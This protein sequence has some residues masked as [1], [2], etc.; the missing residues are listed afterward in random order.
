[1]K[2]SELLRVIVAQVCLHATM[3]G[4]R[5]ATPLLALQQGY[6]A[7]AVGLLIALFALTQV[8]LALPAGRF[9][10]RHGL[11]RPLW[12]SVIAASG[13]AGLAL[14]FPVFPVMCI[15]ALL[16]GGATGA[17]VIALQRHVGRSATDPTQLKRVFSWL[18]IAPAAANFVGPFLAGMLI[19]HAGRAPADLLAFRICFA[20]MAFLPLLCWLLARGAHEPP[21]VA[22]VPGAAPTRAW[23]LLREPMFRR[24]LFVN[25]LQSSSWDVHAFV[26]PVLGH[27]RGISAS[28]IGSILGAFAIAAAVIRIVLPLIAS[29]ASERSVIL[30]STV[31]TAAVFAIYPLLNSPW[32]MGICS[33]VLGFAL[34]AVQPMVMSMLH[35]I[36]P[37]ARHGEALGL[38]LMTIN[39]S[40]V[41]MPMLFGSLGALIGIAGVFW[42]VGGVLALGAKAT[43][44]LKL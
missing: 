12:L 44:G 26:L 21:R 13:G 22:P 8:F 14:I 5:L 43:W 1:M 17:T 16:T 39:A 19:D 33:V 2:G 18:A 41:A 20:V 7:A 4:M 10:D 9:A 6:S 31:V 30:S 11:K 34:G 3:A 15:A 27:D 40:S 32:T 29:R 42:V 35:Q 36:T 24:L 38:R 23:D 28:V 25:W 37:H